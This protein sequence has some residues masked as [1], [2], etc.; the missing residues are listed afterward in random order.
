MTITFS[1]D[2]KER[3]PKDLGELYSVLGF[4]DSMLTDLRRYYM[5]EIA[6]CVEGDEK[7]KAIYEE[8]LNL[9]GQVFNRFE[10]TG[11]FTTGDKYK[12]EC[13][14]PGNLTTVVVCNTLVRYV[15]EN[16]EE[17]I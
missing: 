17:I 9:A 4:F 5:Q 3:T 12:Y 2:F 16:G 15:N 6:K 10:A 1:L 11:F 8:K 7:Q 14:R 13:R